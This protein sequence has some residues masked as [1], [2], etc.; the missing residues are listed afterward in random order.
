[1]SDGR[2]KYESDEYTFDV[3]VSTQDNGIRMWEDCIYTP[4]AAR[5][6]AQALLAAADYSEA[7]EQK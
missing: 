4:E 5:A 7:Q 6:L 2:W 3:Y 1:M